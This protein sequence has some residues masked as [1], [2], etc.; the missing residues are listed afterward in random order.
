MLVFTYRNNKAV[1]KNPD[2][3]GWM[4][5]DDK[6]NIIGVSIKKAI[7]NNPVNDHAVVAT[8]WFKEG[9]IF[10]EAAHRMIQADDRING[11]FYVDETIKH[12]L[13]LG[14]KA[15]VF[16]IKRYLGWGTPEDYEEYQHTFE[17]W[18]GFLEKERIIKSESG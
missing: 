12:I 11:E 8:F 9:R 14:Y 16:E 17:Y 2:S 18:K 3:Y 6:E 7:S 13:E 1:L 4:V 10:V 15:K 5:T